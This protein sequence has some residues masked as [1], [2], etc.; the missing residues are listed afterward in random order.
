MI[1]VVG[2][3]ASLESV[4]AQS[5]S[6]RRPGGSRTAPAEDRREGGLFNRLFENREEVGKVPAEAEAEV[7]RAAETLL[8]D[9]SAL[10]KAAPKMLEKSQELLKDDDVLA[11][12]REGLKKAEAATA[13]NAEALGSVASRILPS[14]S[15]QRSGTP[16]ASRADGTRS[17]S[18]A[19]PAETIGSTVPLPQDPIA[20]PIPRPQADPSKLTRIT[21]SRAEFDANTNVVI[22]EEDVELDHPEF[23]LTCQVLVAELAKDE[24]DPAP[25]DADPTRLAA[26]GGIQKA[27]ARGFVQIEKL[28]PD[29]KVQVAKARQA[30]YDATSGNVTL[31]EFPTLQDGNNLIKGADETTKIFLRS[32]GKYDVVGPAKYELVTESNALMRP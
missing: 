16:R 9:P 17:V 21:A 27:T 20:T 10:E 11:V 12:A 7:R 30:V 14:S 26:A 28:S 15:A 22:F 23:H 1:V 13:G 6:D 32:S 8:E 29:G 18:A 5:S 4:F 3:W 2:C 19:L 25:A 31:A 24:S